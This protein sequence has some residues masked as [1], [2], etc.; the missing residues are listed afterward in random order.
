MP[1]D[2]FQ[3]LPCVFGINVVDLSLQLQDLFRLDGD[4]GGLA[5]DTQQRSVNR[6]RL[7]Y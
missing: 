7:G 4:I 3:Q 6:S 5:L 1:T 2:G